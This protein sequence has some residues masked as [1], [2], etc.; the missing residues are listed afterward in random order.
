MELLDLESVR[1]RSE[2]E[3]VTSQL[4]R[5]ADLAELDGE[6]EDRFRAV[7]ARATVGDL[8]TVQGKMTLVQVSSSDQ[9]F[10]F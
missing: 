8:N 5:L 1:T 9:I 3:A 10:S 4:Y 2:A 6:E 7:V